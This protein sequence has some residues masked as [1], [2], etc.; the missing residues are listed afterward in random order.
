MISRMLFDDG[1]ISI[2]TQFLMVGVG[3]VMINMFSFAI[4]I[5]NLSNINN[6]ISFFKLKF[7]LKQDNFGN[8]E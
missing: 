4:V 2:V 3:Y 5:W 7:S 1:I 8:I 6:W